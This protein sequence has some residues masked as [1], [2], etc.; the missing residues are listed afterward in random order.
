MCT[1]YLNVHC[2]ILPG[3]L[4]SGVILGASIHSEPAHSLSQVLK[5]GECSFWA[6]VLEKQAPTFQ[7]ARDRILEGVAHFPHLRPLMVWLD[8]SREA[9]D[10]RGV[11]QRLAAGKEP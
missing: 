5:K 9:H 2:Q 4:P 6:T 1:A 8:E 3:F 11:L 7:E 10:A